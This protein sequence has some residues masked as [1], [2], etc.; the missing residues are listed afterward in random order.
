MPRWVL[1]SCTFWRL[2]C[3]VDLSQNSK[4]AGS[5]T[6]LLIAAL[7]RG[8]P[9]P[10]GLKLDV[11]KGFPCGTISVGKQNQRVARPEKAFQNPLVKNQGM[12]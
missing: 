8:G 4:A 2:L 3:N 12:A 6:Y 5:N 7:K 1:L 10:S 11:P 9:P